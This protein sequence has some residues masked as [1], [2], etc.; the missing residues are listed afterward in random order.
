[1]IAPAPP[2]PVP[3]VDAAHG[4]EHGEAEHFEEPLEPNVAWSD[5]AA[6]RSYGIAG[7]LASLQAGHL[8]RYILW[9]VLG[10]AVILLVTLA[11]SSAGVS[12]P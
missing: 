10:L 12:R 6:D 8:S 11:G 1:M 4:H 9:S 2:A 7:A 3:A 5:W